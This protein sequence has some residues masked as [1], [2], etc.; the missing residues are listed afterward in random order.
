[1]KVLLEFRKSFQ[2]DVSRLPPDRAKA[3]KAALVKFTN[4][5]GTNSLKFRPLK[6]RPE[7]FIINGHQGDRI[8]LFR[9]EEGVFEV[10]TVG[11][12]DAIYRKMNRI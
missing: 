1:M 7:Y 4:H 9:R 10:V 5:P 12:H 2:K 11:L 6:S 3:V 8:I